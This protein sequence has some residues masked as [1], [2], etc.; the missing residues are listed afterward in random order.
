MLSKDAN[1][2]KC[3]PKLRFFNEKQIEKD[4]DDYYIEN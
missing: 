1:N 4:S 3:A 2:K